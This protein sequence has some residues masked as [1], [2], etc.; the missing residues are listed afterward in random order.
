MSSRQSL[1]LDA[2]DSNLCIRIEGKQGPPAPVAPSPSAS[3]HTGAT[4]AEGDGATGAGRETTTYAQTVF[5]AQPVDW[6]GLSTEA[7]TIH[8][9]RREIVQGCCWQG[10]RQVL[11]GGG[12]PPRRGAGSDVRRSQQRPCAIAAAQ[13]RIVRAESL[14]HGMTIHEI[15]AFQHLSPPESLAEST[16]SPVFS[17]GD[18]RRNPRAP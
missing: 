12:V 6:R 5:L 10:E 18:L 11:P 3:A 4:D 2:R 17:G 9:Q 8:E 1:A 15:R 7:R 16:N 13:S 14:R